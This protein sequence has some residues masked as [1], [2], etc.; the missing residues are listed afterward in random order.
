MIETECFQE[1]N[2]FGPDGTPSP[3]LMLDQ[4]P[5]VEPSGCFPF[6][7]KAKNWKI[8]NKVKTSNSHAHLSLSEEPN[9]SVLLLPVS[10]ASSGIN[11]MGQEL[12]SPAS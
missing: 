5:P 8:P 12:S 6:R 9:S 10:G 3:D 7:K 4:P 2:V 1:L 11:S